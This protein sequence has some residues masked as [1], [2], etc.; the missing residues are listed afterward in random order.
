MA[1]LPPIHLFPPFVIELP[2][3]SF[4]EQPK[5][6]M[7]YGGGFGAKQTKGK[8]PTNPGLFLYHYIWERKKEDHAN[9]T[10]VA[11]QRHQPCHNKVASDFQVKKSRETIRRLAHELRQLDKEP[12]RKQ[13]AFS[14]QMPQS[15]HFGR[16]KGNPRA[17][18][19]HMRGILFVLSEI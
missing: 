16:D 3:E 12:S 18:Y 17:C 11:G 9:N 5:H 14:A 7:E 15:S 8:V 1:G 4:F 2:R 6:E 13:R 10:R 19:P